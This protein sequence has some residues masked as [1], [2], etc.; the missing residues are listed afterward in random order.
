ML[1]EFHFQLG[2]T[3]ASR[4]RRDLKAVT[5]E[6]EGIIVGDGASMFDAEEIIG[7]KFLGPWPVAC[8]SL[9]RYNPEALIEFG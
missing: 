1:A 9:S 8:F 3:A 6:R 2:I 7:T 4:A 5:I